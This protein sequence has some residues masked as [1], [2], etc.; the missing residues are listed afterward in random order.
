LTKFLSVTGGK[1]LRGCVDISGSKNASLPALAATILTDDKVT[2]SNIPELEDI[3][4]FLKLLTSLGKKISIDSKNCISIEGS[5][6]S[7]IAPYEY[8]SAM[9][10]SILVLGPLLT[11]Y[12][13]AIVSLPGGCKI[14]LRPVDLHIK[15]LRQMG[16]EISQDKGNIEAQCKILNGSE[17]LFTK[18]TV[19]GTQNVLMAAVLGRGATKI[20]NAAIEPE[21][22]TLIE[23]LSSMGAQIKLTGTTIYVQGVKKLHGTSFRLGPDRIE[24][25]TYYL[26]V[27]ATKGK[28][29][30][31]VSSDSCIKHTLNQL[32][33]V[34]TADILSNKV[35]I[36]FSNAEINPVSFITNVYPGI[37]T[38]M[39]PLLCVTNSIA[40]GPSVI[41]EQIF[42][43]R[44]QHLPELARL[45]S[46]YEI[47]G[48]EV[49]FEGGSEYTGTTLNVTDLRAG[50][51][52][53][54]GAISAQGKSQIY[55]YFHIL[56]G[57]EN[58]IEK[59]SSLGADIA[60]N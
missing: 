8:V 15:A 27:A 50:A 9:R 42:E 21:V 36:D 37:A 25:A 43:N 17:V 19:T 26:A 57:Y 52:L 35:K 20:L 30:I 46:K 58:F 11:K 53:V 40:N 45:G 28:V 51:A 56:R 59:L 47:Q 54:I 38:D 41:K 18:V 33:A 32:S 49:R 24:L 12:H 39:Q 31:N 23:L 34:G 29:E 7:I 48:N 14:G 44:L 60:V 4:I 6:S 5:L 55:D 16:A 22:I 13:K 2:L 3:S 1:P 10:A